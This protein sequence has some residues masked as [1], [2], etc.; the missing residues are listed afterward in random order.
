MSAKTLSHWFNKACEGTALRPVLTIDDQGLDCEA[1]A[2]QRAQLVHTLRSHAITEG[3]SLA[4]STPSSRFIYLM[5]HACAE[6]GVS[7]FPIDPHLPPQW[8]QVLLENSGVHYLVTT[9]VL[10]FIDVAGGSLS[11]SEVR[12]GGTLHEGSNEVALV[13]ATSGSS[14]EPKGVMLE[15]QTIYNSAVAVNHRLDL[16]ASDCWLNCLPLHHIG[17]LSILFR[18]VLAGAS[19]VLHQGFDATRVWQDIQRV[20]ISHLSLVP[21]MLEQL[22]AVA[23]APPPEFLRVVLIGGAALEPGLAERAL[24]AGWPLFVTY[25]MSETASQVAT[26][27]LTSASA[28]NKPIPLLAGVECSVVDEG[29]ELTNGIGRIR[30]RG[31]LLMRGYANPEQ[32]AGVGLDE[33]GWYTTGDIGS[34]QAGSGIQVGGRAD[35]VIISGGENILPQQVE[36]LLQGC[37]GLSELCVLGVEDSLW[38]ERVCLAYVGEAT[39]QAVERWCRETI[40]GALR[41]RLFVQLEQLPRLSNGKL[42]RHALRQSCSALNGIRGGQHRT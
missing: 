5:L 2:S 12:P 22:L 13:I 33:T 24:A 7:L 35:A 9:D 14:G 23:E 41:P 15:W 29:G 30:L 11:V 21:V 3:Q 26:Q 39:E 10:D 20:R 42:D 17:G 36:R 6:L 34:Y 16:G 31:E 4:L 8:R 25:G 1:L 18:T 40:K 28:I 38:G 37:P 32:R 19:M 27:P